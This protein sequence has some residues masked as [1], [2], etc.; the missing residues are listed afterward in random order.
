[1][2]S[3]V[4]DGEVSRVTQESGLVLSARIKPELSF[5]YSQLTCGAIEGVNQYY[6]NGVDITLSEEQITE[7]ELYISGVTEDVQQSANLAARDYLLLTDWYII[8]FLETGAE[9]PE[10]VSTGR[11]QARLQVIESGE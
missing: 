6:A 2:T 3:F 8:R 5:E 1:M 11:T 9:V 4:Y 7:I 10:D